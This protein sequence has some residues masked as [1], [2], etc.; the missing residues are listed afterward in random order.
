MRR[1]LLNF[2]GIYVNVPVVILHSLYIP[3]IHYHLI[4]FFEYFL[5]I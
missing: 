1:F 5:I 4:F 3:Y 2:T